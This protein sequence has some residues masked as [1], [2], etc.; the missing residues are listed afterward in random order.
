V[1]HTDVFSH[2]NP[3]NPPLATKELSVA[4]RLLVLS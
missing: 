2:Y 4:L 1:Q 3:D